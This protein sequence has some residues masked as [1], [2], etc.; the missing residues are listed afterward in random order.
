MVD[1]YGCHGVAV[2]RACGVVLEADFRESVEDVIRRA[3][4]RAESD[5]FADVEA[6]LERNGVSLSSR[7][8]GVSVR[9]RGQEKFGAPVASRH[10]IG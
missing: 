6:W 3:A 1:R 10:N 4:R 2:G 9:V 7:A 8:A 5:R